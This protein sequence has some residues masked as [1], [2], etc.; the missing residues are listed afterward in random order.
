[1]IRTPLHTLELEGYTDSW[2]CWVV[3]LGFCKIL[4]GVAWIVLVC[5]AVLVLVMVM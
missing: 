1:M 5:M 3:Q 2:G 4:G